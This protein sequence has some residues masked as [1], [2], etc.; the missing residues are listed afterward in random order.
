MVQYVWLARDDRICVF[1]MHTNNNIHIYKPI[2]ICLQRTAASYNICG[3]SLMLIYNSDNRI[4]GI[5]RINYSNC[6]SMRWRVGVP[7]PTAFQYTYTIAFIYVYLIHMYILSLLRKIRCRD[8]KTTYIC[9][10]ACVRVCVCGVV[11]YKF[12]LHV[13]RAPRAYILLNTRYTQE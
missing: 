8:R 5:F 4:T 7:C 12:T 3:M 6:A 11:A 10:H 9:T 2:W 13:C 1:Y